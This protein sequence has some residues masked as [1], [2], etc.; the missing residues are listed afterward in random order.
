M[1]LTY[2]TPFSIN[3]T[4]IPNA[5]N[6][7]VYIAGLFQP[8][9]SEIKSA[10]NEALR[11]FNQFI[12]GGFDSIKWRKEILAF[13]SA[14]SKFRDRKF[15][16]YD[17]GETKSGL[18]KYVNDKL[19]GTVLTTDILCDF[20]L[21]PACLYRSVE[22]LNIH[23]IRRITEPKETRLG[24]YCPNLDKL[25]NVDS[26]NRVMI[27]FS[28]PS[29]ANQQY[30]G[31]YVYYPTPYSVTPLSPCPNGV[32]FKQNDVLG[33][34]FDSYMSSNPLVSEEEIIRFMASQI[35]LKLNYAI[36]FAICPDIDTLRW[37]AATKW[38]LEQMDLF[39]IKHINK[40][41]FY[42]YM[43]LVTAAGVD[44]VDNTIV[45]PLPLIDDVDSVNTT[46]QID[47]STLAPDLYNPKAT[48][49]YV[50]PFNP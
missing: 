16:P 35:L 43:G 38:A 45:N 26:Y 13:K 15:L 46:D 28:N 50:Y 31:L 33:F 10:R 4:A 12:L 20:T 11:L 32:N 30:P 41:K 25:V 42:F 27:H 19:S 22:N 24:L 5:A 37:E 36:S 7:Y 23:W 44:L 48:G 14:P 47:L 9:H 8:T 34:L 18:K 39:T 6:N 2:S 21:P 3:D 1:T 40:A 29:F 49:K 17:V